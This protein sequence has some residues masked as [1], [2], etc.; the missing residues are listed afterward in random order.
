VSCL[1]VKHFFLC[2]NLLFILYII[3]Y[4]LDL[5]LK[6]EPAIDIENDAAGANSIIRLPD[7]LENKTALTKASFL[8]VYR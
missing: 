3:M 1:D 2:N 8:M 7:S 5:I 6:R 4:I